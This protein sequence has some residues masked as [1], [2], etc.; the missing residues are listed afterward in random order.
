MILI[1]D[2]MKKILTIIL[3]GFGVRDSEVGNAIKL[4]NMPHYNSL[5]ETYPHS[6]LSAS[7]EAVGLPVGQFG[8]SEIGHLTIGAGRVI[9][10]KIKVIN[11]SLKNNEFEQNEVFNSVIH[12]V[13][14]NNSTL[15]LIGLVSDGGVHSHIEYFKEII[16]IL[17]L[18]EVTNVYFH[19][20]TDGRDT[21]VDSGVNF[22]KDLEQLLADS[23]VGKMATVCGRYFAMDRDQKYER[24]KSYYD[25]IVNRLGNRFNNAD[26]ALT[27]C[28]QKGIYDEFLPP[29]LIDD[30]G[31]IKS[32]DGVFWLNFRP[33]RA[34]QILSSLTNS[35]FEGF[36]LTSIENLKVI[37]MFPTAE[38]VKC[39][40]IFENVTEGGLSL[41]KYLAELGMTQG[42]VAET[43]KYAHV[44]YYFDGGVDKK[45]PGAE[46]HLLQSPKVAT[47]DSVPE[48]RALDITKKVIGC[49]D[50]D[51]DFVLVNFANADMLGHTGIIEATVKGLEAIDNCLGEIIE[52]AKDNFY[53]IVL[54]ADHGNA[55][56][57]LDEEGKPVTTHSLSKVPFIITDQ[58]VKLKDGTLADVAPTILSYMDIAV[59]KE[60]SESN[61]L[62]E[63]I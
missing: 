14:Q 9:K 20:I 62:F 44:T 60:M 6:L 10:S 11:D 56:Y 45:L 54:L 38:S 26:E 59:P 13:K 50:K 63:Y 41:G 37:S 12:H 7:E 36:N 40:H 34:V 16:R 33:D 31:M 28:Y 46:Y 51:L 17:Q 1:G 39:E 42:R 2:K 58:K 52:S 30:Q 3:D 21:K 4:A 27:Y 22:I 61:V 55:D 15:H 5:V 18:K 24:T 8:N 43:E 19:A 23:N 49:M 53:T 57:M 35:E 47:Y 25:L 29:I 32:N 48:M